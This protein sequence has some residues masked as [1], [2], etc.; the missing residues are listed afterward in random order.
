MDAIVFNK[1]SQG[2]GYQSY[3]VFTDRESMFDEVITKGAEALGESK[4]DFA[5]RSLDSHV[6]EIQKLSKVMSSSE[7]QYPLG[8]CLNQLV[9]EYLS[10]NGLVSAYIYTKYEIELSLLVQLFSNSDYLYDYP[11]YSSNNG[12]LNFSLQLGTPRICEKDGNNYVNKYATGQGSYFIAFSI[13]GF[14]ATNIMTIVVGVLCSIVGLALIFVI[15]YYAWLR[16]VIAKKRQLKDLE[17]IESAKQ[18]SNNGGK[19]DA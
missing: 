16:K 2:Y 17:A 15:V 8:D 14:E 1:D 3:A 7:K 18:D 19:K 12:C 4:Q 6:D 5:N 10:D 13:Y 9:A 11:S